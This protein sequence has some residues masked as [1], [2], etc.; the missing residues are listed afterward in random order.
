MKKRIAFIVILLTICLN[1]FCEIKWL[2]VQEDNE[3]GITAAALCDTEEEVLKVT[4]WKD[5]ESHF[6]SYSQDKDAAGADVYLVVFMR[7]GT[8]VYEYHKGSKAVG[9]YMKTIFE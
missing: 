1:A 2:D 7:V 3:E 6:I 8:V 5:L 4:H 9:C